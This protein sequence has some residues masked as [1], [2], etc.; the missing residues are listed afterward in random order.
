MKATGVL[1]LSAASLLLAGC[2]TFG[3]LTE[4]V[5]GVFGEDSTQSVTA[6]PPATP[7][8]A[9]SA[10]VPLPV[11]KPVATA[12]VAPKAAVASEEVA[13]E[14]MTAGESLR[15]AMTGMPAYLALEYVAAACWL[16]HVVHGGA[17]LG[18]RIKREV[19]ITSESDDLL[20]AN[21]RSAGDGTSVVTLTGPA[22][23]N[24]AMLKR[25]SETLATSVRTGDP[26][27]SAVR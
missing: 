8:T 10:T 2:A 18:D 24:P 6:P 13:P 16:D 14:D 9:G 5:T 25:L 3:N 20:I 22:S 27:C 26:H 21:I 11:P 19:T 23:K 7:P 15:M 12:V 4:S 1:T 17:M